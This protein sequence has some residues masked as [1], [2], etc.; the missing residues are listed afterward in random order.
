MN[1]KFKTMFAAVF[2]LGSVAIA[3][4]Q[5]PVSVFI[6]AG[7]SNADGR[8]YNDELPDYLKGGYRYLHFANV[9]REGG[10]VFDERTFCNV[11]DRWAFCDVTNYYIE[12]A[13]QTDF[14]AIK[15][16]YGGTAIDTAATHA[17]QPVWCA[18][19]GWIAKNKAYRGD[20]TVGKSLTKSLT[21][22]F[23]DCVDSTLSH[24]GSGYDVK[25]IMWHQGESDRKQ[26]AHYYKNFKDMI[27]YMRN[28]IYRKTGK[29][30][31]K[32]VPF[33]FGTVSHRSKQYSREVEQAQRRVAAELPNVYIVDM[34]MAGLR[35]DN[36][37]FDAAWTEYLGRMMYNKLVEVGVLEGRMIEVPMPE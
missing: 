18:D 10:G 32:N 15:A 27:I 14:Y 33:I 25:A 16:T 22:G 23:V 3:Q 37:H 5:K 1:Q 6:T 8:V 29:E 11:K 7:Q 12:Q 36:L 35:S 31:D 34:S 2:L 26:A 9:T 13:L 28:A 19:E 20:G 30:K 24:I 17:H 21:E 4:A